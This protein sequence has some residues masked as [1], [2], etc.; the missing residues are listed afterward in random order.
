MAKASKPAPAA[1]SRRS[2][3]SVGTGRPLPSAAP[4]LEMGVAGTVIYGGRIQ[5]VERSSEW[6]GLQRWKTASDIVTNVSI[7]AAS[8]HYFLNMIAHPQWTVVPA[9][10]SAQAK[11]LAEFT[12]QALKGMETPWSQ[13]VRKAGMYRFNGFGIQEWTVK[14]N[15]KGQNIVLI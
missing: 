14:K 6:I 1:R 5:T 3:L 15:E 4:G 2:G 11:E 9:N 8:I 10:D 7:V 13:V 12:D